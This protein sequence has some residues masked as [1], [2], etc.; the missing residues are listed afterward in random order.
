MSRLSLVSVVIINYNGKKFLRDCFSSLLRSAYEPFE[1]IFVDN[2]STD[3]SVR[4]VEENFKDSRVRII[5]NALNAGV[6]AGRN[7]GFQQ[8]HGDYVVFLDNDA[9]VDKFW[10][11]ELTAVFESDPKIAV[12]QCKLLNMVE[13]RK[14]DHAGD[15]LTPFGFLYERSHQRLDRGQFDRVE[16]IFNAKGAATMI[17]SSVFRQLGMYDDS[18]FMYLEE[19]DFCFRAWLA[20]YRVVFAPRAVAWHAFNTPLKETAKH[21][22]NFVVRFYGSRNYITTHIKNLSLGYLLRILPVHVLGWF[23]LSVVFLLK[24]KFKDSFWILKGMF[25][26]LSHL[27]EILKKRFHVQKNIRKVNDASFLSR[28]M[29][30]RPLTFYFKKAGCYLSGRAFNDPF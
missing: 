29:V 19:T 27:P 15:Y 24:G 6:P 11:K 3:G 5:K 9:E 26:N 16:D 7:I 25:W 22:S 1:V 23:V 8:A 14:F 2:A 20:G 28:V 30:N 10:L 4:Y 12:A 13:R 18:Y 17:R 21:Y